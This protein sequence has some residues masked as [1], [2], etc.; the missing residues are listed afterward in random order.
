[1]VDKPDRKKALFATRSQVSITN[2][3]AKD[4]VGYSYKKLVTALGR[5]FK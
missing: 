5:E 4:K 1:M 2:E 3:A